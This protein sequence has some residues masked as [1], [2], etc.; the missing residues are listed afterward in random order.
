[1]HLC[2]KTC[3]RSL[4][5]EDTN[6]DYQN[7]CLNSQN[8]AQNIY[9]YC[10]DRMKD[11]DTTMKNFCKL[12]MCNLCCVT[13]DPIKK[14]NYSTDNIKKCFNDCSSKFNTGH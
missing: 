11:Y 9:T 7:T 2:K 1:M 4:L 8:S 3:Y 5:S 12:D 6:K 14:K 10:D 13:M